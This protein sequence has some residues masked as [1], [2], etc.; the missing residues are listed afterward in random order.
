M[1]VR[2]GSTE[3]LGRFQKTWKALSTPIC[4]DHRM[5]VWIGPKYTTWMRCVTVT[6]ALHACITS[7]AY[8]CCCSLF[9]SD[10]SSIKADL[11]FSRFCKNWS[12]QTVLRW[13]VDVSWWTF[14]LYIM[15]RTSQFALHFAIHICTIYAFTEFNAVIRACGGQCIFSSRVLWQSINVSASVFELSCNCACLQPRAFEIEMVRRRDRDHL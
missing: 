9:L 3:V 6:L 15:C 4:C 1:L 10:N 7:V 12:V 5:I 2:T 13:R 11:W 14:R 8:M